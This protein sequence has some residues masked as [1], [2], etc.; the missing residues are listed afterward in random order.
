MSTAAPAVP[1]TGAATVRG[2]W[3]SRL[4]AFGP[5]FVVAVLLLPWIISGGHAWPWRPATIDLDVY[6]YAVRD[7]LAGRDIY[8]TRSPGWNLTFIYPPVAAVL[9]TPAAFGPLWLWQLLWTAGGV[10]AQQYVLARCGAPGG[11]RLGL[12]GVAVVLGVEPI[13]TTLGYGQVNTLLM[14]LVV[15]DLLGRRRRF[16]PRGSL[17]GLATAV[18]LTPALFAV[19][20]LAHG[21]WRVTLRAFLTFLALTAVGSCCSR[22]RAT[23]S[24]SPSPAATPAPRPARSTSATS[25]CSV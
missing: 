23:S 21:R 8:D 10:A 7:M 17:I 1:A 2:R 3:G 9:L 12:L 20:T 5:P 11:W 18:K 22:G 15:A 16:P 13:R 4:L 25:R 14:F 19:F 6:G 24:G